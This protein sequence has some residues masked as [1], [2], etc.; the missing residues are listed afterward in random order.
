MQ[1]AIQEQEQQRQNTINRIIQKRNEQE[2]AFRRELDLQRENDELLL[3]QQRLEREISLKKQRQDLESRINANAGSRE[4]S[5]R[6]Q[7]NQQIQDWQAQIQQ[8]EQGINNAKQ[9]V[10]SFFPWLGRG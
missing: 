8:A 9:A 5:L 6:N 7:S 1:E 10:F 2:V 4:T 3:E